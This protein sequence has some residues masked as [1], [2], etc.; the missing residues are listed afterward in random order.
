MDNMGYVHFIQT[1]L[2]KLQGFGHWRGV[3]YMSEV[4]SHG[5]SHWFY[6]DECN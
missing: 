2:S 3:L 6:I 1:S 5:F 4:S